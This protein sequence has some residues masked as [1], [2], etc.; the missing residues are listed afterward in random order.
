MIA[1]NCWRWYRTA[2]ASQQ[3]VALVPLSVAHMSQQSKHL[4]E[5]GPF[6]LDAGE[7]LLQRDGESV[8]LTPKAFDLLLALVEHHG[9]LLEKDELLKLVWPDTFVEEANLSYNISL[10]RKALSDGENGHRYIETVPKRGYRF[11]DEVREIGAEQVKIIEAALEESW[12]ASRRAEKSSGQGRRLAA[13]SGV[14]TLIAVM[15]AV[16]YIL[17][18][19]V[20]T[21]A[22]LPPRP[23]QAGERDQALELGT[24]ST[25]ITRLGSLRQLIV[26]PES[27]VEK[28]AKPDQDPLAAGREQ[29]VDAVLDSRYQRSGDRSRFTLRLLRVMDGATLWSDTLDQQATDLFALEDALSAKVSG[30]L[31]I[32]LN[33]AEKELLAKRYT[34]SAEAWQLYVRGRLLV[35]KRRI[36][37]IEKAIAYLEQAITLDQ[38][39]A[40]AH[41]MLG[42]AYISRNFLGDAPATEIM[43]KT[44]AAFDQAL[45][46]DNQLAEVHAC[47][48]K[49]KEYY[50]W[51]FRGAETLYRRALDLNPNSADVHHLYA[52]SL[53][54][55]GRSEQ[56]MLEIRRAEE[57][58]PTD[59]FIIRNVAQVLFFTRRYDEAIEQSRRAVDLHPNSGPMYH[60]MIRAYEM[61]GDE[62]ATFAAYLKQAEASGAGTDEIAGMKAAFAADGLKGHWR[63]ELGRQLELEKSRYV[64]QINSRCST[65]GWAR[66]NRRLRGCTGQSKIT[67]SSPLRSKLNLSGT[68]IAPTLVLWR[69]CSASDSRRRLGKGRLGV[70][71]QLP[72]ARSPRQGWPATT[73]PAGISLVTTLPAPMTEPSPMVTPGQ[74][75][76]PPPIRTQ[77]CLSHRTESP[78]PP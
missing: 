58:D 49:Y 51:D 32:T 72:L 40:L 41:S 53:S 48:A 11:V 18:T 77:N 56:A 12:A 52:M 59:A 69:W 30:A 6:R 39:F 74:T 22:V 4:Y 9:H 78:P 68:S 64:G 36:P 3:A 76:T 23:L 38:G 20:K 71:S 57:L 44:K 73:T 67:T 55:A 29:K 24:T 42:F 26:R 75:I 15:M 43:P 5:F 63:R 61:K 46:L 60:W 10:I 37:D 14:V 34:N 35:H 31:R 13:I 45:K 70:P 8:P 47:L 19:P 25:L 21:I 62:Q 33:S 27:A 16:Y 7:R 65:R 1:Y 28:Y 66:R 2:I 50:E 17:E 54:Y